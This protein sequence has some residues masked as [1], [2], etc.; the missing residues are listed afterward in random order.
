MLIIAIIVF[1]FT[2][3]LIV[4]V[5]EYGHFL[6]AIRN[7]VKV[8]EFGIGYPPRATGWYKSSK[9][10]K[11]R[12]FKNK[13]NLKREDV[14]GTIYSINWVPFGGFCK[15]KGEEEDIKAGDSFS[16]KSPWSRAKIIVGG[17]LFNFLLAWVL[18]T[19][20]YWFA[21]KEVPNEVVVVSVA[22][23]SAASEAGIKNNDFIKSIDGVEV[24]NIEDLQKL[25][26]ER[27]GKDIK[28]VVNHFGKEEVREVT[29]PENTDAPLGVS[30]VETGAD[31]MPDLVW[32]KAPWYA[33]EEIV[34]VIWMS[35][36][37]L[38]GLLM[39]LIGRAQVST[40][41][42]SGPIGVFSFLYQI[43]HLGPAYILRFIALISVAVGFFN[44]L[45]FPALDG[46]H[47]VFIAAEAIRGK[48]IMRQEY[49]NIF[50]WIGFA[51]L[52]ILFVII[53][54]KDIAKLIIK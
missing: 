33:L 42:V 40:E 50:H 3:S 41:G 30:L 31:E 5:H 21:P 34:L 6:F 29:L 26:K 49:E 45:P 8:E 32:W 12:F 11:W 25:T 10:G 37:F 19:G 16:S 13:N 43:I 28:M 1:I 4:L 51:I 17:V 20:W 44:I 48:K 9:T 18:L 27:Q 39:T 38:W 2:L 52:I 36:S 46:G 22:D 54:Y 35:L 7:G 14:S 23:G 24:G 15:M 47:L 53:T